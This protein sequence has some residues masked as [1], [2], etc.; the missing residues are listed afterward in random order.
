MRDFAFIEFYTIDVC[1]IFVFDLEG[2]TLTF[3]AQE[4]ETVLKMTQAPD[5]KINGQTVTV[6]F[7]KSRKRDVPYENFP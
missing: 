4:A 2:K 5:F 6:A 3:A 7:S 1:F